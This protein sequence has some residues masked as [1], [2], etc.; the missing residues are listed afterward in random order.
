MIQRP[1]PVVV[2]VKAKVKVDIAISHGYT[3]CKLVTCKRKPTA[4]FW[5]N[6]MLFW[7]G[8]V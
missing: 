8:F 2:K 3:F 6:K 7:Q 5:E 1:L 4:G